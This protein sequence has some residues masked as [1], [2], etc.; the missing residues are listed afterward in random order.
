MQ[1]SDLMR[2][3][4]LALRALMT[5][6]GAILAPAAI[7]VSIAALPSSAAAA[8]TLDIRDG[9]TAVV[10]IS[11]LDQTRVRAV[12]AR[13]LDVIGDV[14]DAQANPGGR[15]IV[16]KDDGEVYLKPIVDQGV[17]ARPI[18][19]DVKTSSG[20]V[21]LLL[22]PAE[23]VGDT[24]TLRVAGGTQAGAGG[25]TPSAR[26]KSPA[27]LR[28]VKA[29][30]LAM[31]VPGIAADASIQVIDGGA[32]EV[33]LWQEARFVLL[34]RYEAGQLLG[35]T[36]QLT[37]VSKSR[38]VLD[39]RELFRPGVVSVSALRLVLEPGESTRVWVVR[40]L[41]EADEV[42]AAGRRP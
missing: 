16:L 2:S 41:D 21:G 20:T 17:P 11:S 3:Q 26:V 19:L 37:N 23:I 38:M 42:A 15:V 18:K 35:E 12:R 5:H 40:S 10:R 14:Y 22:Q 4:W 39:E 7:A 32:E 25:A 9:D 34:A 27:H 24:L 1:R 6:L 13:V 28:A 36:F 8:Q 29:L 31:A 30:T 33:L